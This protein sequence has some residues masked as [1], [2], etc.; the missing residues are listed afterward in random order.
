MGADAGRFVPSIARMLQDGDSLVRERAVE[1]L[2]RL[3]EFNADVA[4][5]IGSALGAKDWKVRLGAVEAA[6]QSD[7]SGHRFRHELG[8]LRNDENRLVSARATAVLAVS[9]PAAASASK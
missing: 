7:L 5:A 3:A 9:L 4:P 6:K 1:A 8:R 2:G